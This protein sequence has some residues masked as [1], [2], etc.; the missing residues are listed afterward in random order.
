MEIELTDEQRKEN[1]MRARRRM[2]DLIAS[3][4]HSE[5]ELRRKLRG[6][7]DPA[8]IDAAIEYGKDHGWVP[9]DDASKSK[10][11]DKMAAMLHR[12][13]KGIRYINQYL[14][15]RGLPPVKSAGES[16]LEKALELLE[17]RYPEI[18]TAD[19]ATRTKAGRFLVS[20]GYEMDIV[21]KIV[22]RK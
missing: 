5:K 3:R 1:M 9:S 12:K 8:D 11:A 14:G 16:E 2:M 21:R 7:F 19:E 22:F 20:R 15:E 10:L 17:T 13:G 18:E 6:K 4:D